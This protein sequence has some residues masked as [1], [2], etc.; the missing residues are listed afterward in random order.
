MRSSFVGCLGGVFV[1]SAVM[2]GPDVLADQGT[3]KTEV[4]LPAAVARAIKDNCPTFEIKKVDVTKE[5][6]VTLYDVEFKGNQG[7]IEIAEDG[8]VLDI[9]T[10]IEMKD[11]PKAAADVIAKFALGAKI[12]R[13][14]RSQV[15]AELEPGNKGR[16]LK[17]AKAK[18]VYEA[19]LTKGTQAAEIQVA[20]DGKVIEEPAW[21]A[22][23]DEKEDVEDAPKPNVKEHTALL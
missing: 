16:L 23:K 7:E 19:E 14:E 6:G 5:N 17:L 1:L 2:A 15:R 10:V 21:G 11:V 20:P 3:S 18:I 9:A 8:T 13:V 22:K 4:P 12:T